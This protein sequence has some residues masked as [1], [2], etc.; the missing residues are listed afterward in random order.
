MLMD[1]V[2]LHVVP[3]NHCHGGGWGGKIQ[4]H[5]L[6]SFE[7]QVWKGIPY[8]ELQ[9]YNGGWRIY[10][11]EWGWKCRLHKWP[12]LIGDGRDHQA[13]MKV[14]APHWAFSVPTPAGDQ[15]KPHH[16]LARPEV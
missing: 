12:P 16:N 14:L 8:C 1:K 9:W 3:P 6:A 11:A 13:G 7:T 2:G 10:S 15:E 4:C 5:H